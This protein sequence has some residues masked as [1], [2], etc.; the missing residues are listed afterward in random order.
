MTA[1][2]AAAGGQRVAALSTQG[3]ELSCAKRESPRVVSVKV[4]SRKVTAVKAAPPQP[5]LAFSWVDV[6]HAMVDVYSSGV[7]AAIYVLGRMGPM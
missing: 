4:T 1:C 7:L 3:A 6:P 2:I 5:S